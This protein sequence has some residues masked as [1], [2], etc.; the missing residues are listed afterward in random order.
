M[1]EK[2]TDYLIIGGGISGTTAAET[3]RSRDKNGSIVIANTEP[4]PLYCRIMISKPNFFLEEIPKEHIWLKSKKWYE[5]KN[6]ELLSGKTILAL[7]TSGKYATIDDG[8]IIKYEKLLIATGRSPQKLKVPRIDKEGVF[9]MHTVDNIDAIQKK[10]KQA[11]KAVVIGGGLIGFE[12]SNIL[13]QT[14]LEVTLLIRGDRILRKVISENDSRTIEKEM[15]K[16][17]VQILKNEEVKEIMGT[18]SVESIIA[19]NSKIIPCQ[20][21]IA[22]IGTAFISGP[23]ESAGIKIGKGVIVNEYLE[24][25]LPDIWAAGDAVEF[26]ARNSKE[27][28]IIESWANAI[29]QGKIAGLNMIGEHDPH[30]TIFSR[31]ASGFG[32]SLSITGQSKYRLTKAK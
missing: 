6:I 8:G 20:I 16:S 9:S 30:Q 7:D 13:R 27:G 29:K 3:I 17:G 28:V 19:K 2:K 5:E 15:S 23:F 12:A 4:H 11:K 31:S 10:A 1:S 18:K 25:N 32:F 24:T 22:A 21:I 26:C 14:G